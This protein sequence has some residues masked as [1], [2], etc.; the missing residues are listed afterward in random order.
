M[1]NLKNGYSLRHSIAVEDVHV[2]LE[3]VEQVLRPHS[4]AVDEFW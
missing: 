4:A 3:V 1:P 2:S